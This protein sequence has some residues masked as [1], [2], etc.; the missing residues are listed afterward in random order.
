MIAGLLA[1]M[2]AANAET[3]PFSKYRLLQRGMSAA[4]VLYQ[5]GPP[6]FRQLRDPHWT[7]MQTW[8]YIP[9]P[10]DHDPWHTIIQFDAYG[11]IKRLDRKKVL[12][13]GF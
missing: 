8:Y 11:Y 5:A 12:K 3:L 1:G 7:N 6:D 10:Q 4:E 2:A 9:T 13:T